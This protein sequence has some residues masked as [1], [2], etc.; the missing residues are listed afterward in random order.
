[1]PVGA[2]PMLKQEAEK[3]WHALALR[4]LT[5]MLQATVGKEQVHAWRLPPAMPLIPLWSCRLRLTM[6]EAE[7]I[8]GASGLDAMFTRATDPTAVH[9]HHDYTIVWSNRHQ[10]AAPGVLT[11]LL[12]HARQ[13]PGHRGAARSIAGMLESGL[14]RPGRK[15][16]RHALLLCRGDSRYHERNIA[17]KDA[18]LYNRWGTW[19]VVLQPEDPEQ[20]RKKRA[21][22]NKKKMIATATATADPVP[23][24]A[25]PLHGQDPW[26]KYAP[27][28]QASSSSMPATSSTSADT[29]FHD[30]RVTELF[31][32]TQAVATKH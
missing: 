8:I 3:D 32:R 28:R 21:Q 25:D 6:E 20:L 17:I 29:Q 10:D 19:N 31:S 23:G 2:A 12:H 14:E 9:A 18:Q 13:I 30:Q 26:A 15:C 1:M 22:A 5:A 16:V 4:L 11:Q 27:T 24:K 7:K